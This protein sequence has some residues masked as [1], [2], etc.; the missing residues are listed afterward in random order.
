MQQRHCG[1]VVFT[2]QSGDVMNTWAQPVSG[3]SAAAVTQFTSGHIYKFAW[4]ATGGLAL[5]LAASTA[6]TQ[7]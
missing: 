5:S 4:S 2:D 7:C 1:E 3:G 6:R